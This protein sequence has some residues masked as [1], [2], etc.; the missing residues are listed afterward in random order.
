[1][2]IA[3]KR[4]RLDFRDPHTMQLVKSVHVPCRGLDHI[5][6]TVDNRSMIATCEF[7]AHLVKVDLATQ[8]VVGSLMLAPTMK[9]SMPQDIRSSPDGSVFYVADMKK[10]G[11]HVIDPETM[12]YV[13]FIPT[14][15][16]AHGITVGRAGRVFYISNRGW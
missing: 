15:K 14:G 11:V 13:G 16:G 10:D 2:V 7:S 6:F 12:T 1:I 3:E 4:Q 9:E 8:T 5:D